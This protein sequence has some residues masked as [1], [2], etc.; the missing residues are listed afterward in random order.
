MKW[1]FILSL[2]ILCTIIGYFLGSSLFLGPC[3]LSEV[4]ISKGD[5]YANFI[6]LFAAVGTFI[7][8]LVALFMDEIRSLFKKVSFKIELESSDV[9]EDV[10]NIK[11]TKK[12]KRYHNSVLIL[13]EGNINARNCELYLESACYYVEDS[14]NTI[15][16]ENSPIKWNKDNSAVYIP[17]QGKKTLLLFEIFAPQKQSTPDGGIG[18]TTTKFKILGLE[19]MDAKAGKWEFSYCL[20]SLNSKPQKFKY[21]IEWNGNWE[22]RQTEMKNV[23]KMKLELL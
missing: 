2:C 5:Y 21:I 11:G 18:I 6:N 14:P 23:L 17:F 7:A 19:E 10:E 12:A 3:E 13:N 16:V 8:V 22:E 9:I 20:N 4:P 15:T 1:K